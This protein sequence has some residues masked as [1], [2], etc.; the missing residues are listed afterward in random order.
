MAVSVREVP[1]ITS[2]HNPN[3]QLSWVDISAQGAVPDLQGLVV[4]I[5]GVARWQGWGHLLSA[6]NLVDAA[7]LPQYPV[8]LRTDLGC[9]SEG[10]DLL[11]AQGVQFSRVSA[12]F[13]VPS[14]AV[15]MVLGVL[16]RCS[17]L[18]RTRAP[19]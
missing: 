1:M 8:S 3:S 9:K 18:F 11:A 7:L 2:Q 4:S 16:P 5:P 6:L 10:K 17:L 19:A 12:S 15:L 13:Q 14:K